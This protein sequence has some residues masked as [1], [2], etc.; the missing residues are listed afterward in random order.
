LSKIIN[1]TG[2]FFLNLNK[3][4]FNIACFFKIIFSSLS[5][6]IISFIIFYLL[7]PLVD[8]VQSFYDIKIKKKKEINKKRTA[9][10]LITFSII[11][12]IISLIIYSV[13]VKINNY[14]SDNDFIENLS[15]FIKST[16]EDFD[17]TYTNAQKKLKDLG[18]FEYFSILLDSVINLFNEMSNN[19]L[20]ILK[21]TGSGI[22]N[23]ILSVVMTF[24][25][26]RDKNKFI[27]TINKICE[28]FLPK[29]ILEKL[30][31]ILEDVNF[32]LSGYISGQLLDALIMAVLLSLWLSCIRVKFAVIIGLFSGL[33]NVIPYV[34]A[35]MCFILSVLSAFINGEYHKAFYAGIGVLALQQFDGLYLGPKIVGDRVELSPFLIILSLSIAGK[36]FGILGML[37]AVPVCAVIKIFLS[38]YI[39]RKKK[40]KQKNF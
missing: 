37:F 36:T 10:T 14:D 5:I 38:R 6:F 33:A 25:L 1:I 13:V 32:V 17:D 8:N 18:L 4:F 34:G 24:Y 12:L 23:S 31:N 28:I 15:N 9:G 22:L 11:I 40:H 3:I 16:I 30:K 7:D 39:E 20:N 27:K 19:I 2:Y 21:S 35:I 26:L 29:K